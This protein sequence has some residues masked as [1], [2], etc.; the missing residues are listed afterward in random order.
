VA[1]KGF[2]DEERR[3]AANRTRLAPAAPPGP[4]LAER[5][6]EIAVTGARV[7]A[8]NLGGARGDW[9]A[10]TVDDPNRDLADCLKRLD[11][12]AK[13]DDVLG[14]DLAEGIS[15]AWAGETDKAIAAFDRAIVRA[16][17]S[18]FAYL[19]RGLARRQGGDLDR[20]RADLDRAVKYGPREARN[21]YVRSLILRAQGATAR[22]RH[23][24]DRAVELDPAYDAIVPN[25]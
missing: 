24:E 12:T 1:P 21:Y 16:P 14:T 18:A 10:C 11:R 3:V 20:A 8:P 25:R 23:D 22:A 15:L 7:R 2:V 9:N 4:A 13:G 6:G 19:N 17:K 5:E